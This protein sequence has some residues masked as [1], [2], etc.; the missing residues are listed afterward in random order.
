MKFP[1]YSQL[2]GNL[3]FSETSSQLTPPSSGESAN[4]R[5]LAVKGARARRRPTASMETAMLVLARIGLLP[6]SGLPVLAAGSVKALLDPAA[7]LDT[8]L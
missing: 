7:S 8:L 3:A 1:V 6:S 5:F 4:L 2:A